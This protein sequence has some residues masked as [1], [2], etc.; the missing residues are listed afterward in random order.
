M[1]LFVLLLLGPVALAQDDPAARTLKVWDANG[2]GVLSAD[3]FPDEATFKKADRDGN[4][5]VTEEEIAIFL[6]LKKAPPVKKKKEPKPVKKKP[7]RPQG[8]SVSDGGMRKQPFTVPERVK[9]F[10]R[11]FDADKNR[12]VDKKEAQGI[13]D[14]LWIRFDRNK[15]EAFSYKEA[16]RY[17]RY[18]LTE[19]KKRPNRANFFELFDRNRDK[20]VTRAEYDGP[21]QF[22][23]QYDHDRNKVVTE[24]ELNMGPNA[25]TGNRRQME[26]DEKFMADGP[27]R[28]PKRNLLDRYDKDG[29]G[30][31]TLEELNGAEA[32]M[33]RLDTN[34]DGV[35]SGRE[36]K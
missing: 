32:L 16:T 2:D 35:L 33:Q 30:R 36:A 31:I 1:R 10:F 13:G 23:R 18:Q 20:K 5:K 24:E 19:A 25:G 11:R 8:E 7:E 15:D 28:A 29:D 21:A 14:D 22:F 26:A 34:G 9:D 6:G 17:I 3:E 12:K 4:G 27:T